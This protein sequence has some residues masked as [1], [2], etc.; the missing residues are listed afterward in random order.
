MVRR[1]H[2]KKLLVPERQPPM[3]PPHPN[4]VWS[5]DFVFDEQAKGRRIKTLTGVDDRFSVPW[6]ECVHGVRCKTRVETAQ[7]QVEYFGYYNIE[8][9]RWALGSLAPSEF[10]RRRRA[11]NQSAGRRAE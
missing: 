2:R 1:R 6:V 3:R 9:L 7:A 8:C 4:E 10:E 5:M 11:E